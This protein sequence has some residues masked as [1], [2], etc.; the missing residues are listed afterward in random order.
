MFSDNY[1]TIEKLIYSLNGNTL[2]LDSEELSNDLE[3]FNE[4][5]KKKLFTTNVSSLKRRNMKRALIDD[6]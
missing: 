2:K 1:K 3:K 4:I 5:A 6:D